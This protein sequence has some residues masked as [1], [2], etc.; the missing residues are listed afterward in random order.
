[1]KKIYIILIALILMGKIS[2]AQI[3]TGSSGQI[4][5]PNVTSN[6]GPLGSGSLLWFTSGDANTAIQEYWGLNLGGDATRPVRIPFSSLLV[7][8]TNTNGNTNYGTGNAYISGVVGIGTTTVP[9]GYTFAVNGSGIATSFTVQSYANWPDYVFKSNY[10]LPS[11]NN[12][13]AYIDQNHHLPDVPSAEQVAKDGLNL[14]DMNKITMQKVEELTLYLIEKDKEL[15]NER[16]INNHQQ[17]EIDNQ[18]SIVNQQSKELQMLQEQV[19]QL[20]KLTATKNAS[21]SN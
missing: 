10:R 9:T 18:K 20:M 17:Q 4:E 1:M 13:K 12:V 7:G 3:I 5:I 21:R 16:Q 15:N 14:G 8:Y 11:L 6:A 2:H 19:D